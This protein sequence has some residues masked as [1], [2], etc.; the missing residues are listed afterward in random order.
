[1]KTTKYLF[2]LIAI[3]AMTGISSC[4]KIDLSDTPHPDKGQVTLTTDWTN[5]SAGIALPAS[6]TVTVAGQTLNYTQ[7][8]NVL[9][10]LDPGMY[11]IIEK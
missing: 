2:S 3:L 1:M 8:A 11:N 4:V 7:A 9:P 5:R 10:L 6:Y